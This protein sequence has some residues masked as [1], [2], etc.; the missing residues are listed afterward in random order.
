MNAKYQ[1]VG[2]CSVYAAIDTVFTRLCFWTDDLKK[3]EATLSAAMDK[4]PPCSG[5]S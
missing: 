2:F 3:L 4:S 1:D 5:R